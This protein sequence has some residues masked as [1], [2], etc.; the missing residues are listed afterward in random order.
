M[1]LVDGVFVEFVALALT[2]VGVLV[3]GIAAAG[4]RAALPPRA[5]A[6]LAVSVS[7]ALL[8]WLAITAGLAAAGVLARWD[9]TPPRV[10]FLL[11]RLA[12]ATRRPGTP[13]LDHA[14]ST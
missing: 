13:A 10:A 2:M 3:A 14:R 4:R 9:T 8:A 12:I 7:A 1:T 5:V 6:G 11:R